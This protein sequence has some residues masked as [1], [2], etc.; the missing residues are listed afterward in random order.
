MKEDLK[1]PTPIIALQ[2]I[3]AAL[4]GAISKLYL[5]NQAWFIQLLA[6]IVIFSIVYALVGMIYLKI[7]K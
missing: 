1:L 2:V 3:L 6:F 7:K 5:Q 4:S